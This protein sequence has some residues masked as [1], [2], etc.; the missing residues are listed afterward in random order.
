MIDGKDR[1]SGWSRRDRTEQQPQNHELQSK[2]RDLILERMRFTI[3]QRMQVS[4][5]RKRNPYFCLAKGT[6]KGSCRADS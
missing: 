3:A 5:D 6:V 2:W 1:V 4:A